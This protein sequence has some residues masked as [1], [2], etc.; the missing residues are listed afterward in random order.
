MRA[1]ISA[2]RRTDIP[3]FY[4]HWLEYHL[5]QGFVDVRNPVVKDKTY[6]VSLRPEDVHTIVLWSKNYRPFLD[7]PVSRNPAYH[8]YFNFSLV[9]CPEWER[10]VPPLE[11]RLRQARELAARWS[12]HHIN[13]RFDPILFWEGGRRNNLGAFPSLCDFMA[14]LGVFWCTFSF[15]TWYNKVKAR[16]E[17]RSLD[18][19]DPPLS[20]KV[21]ILSGLSA[22]TRPRG[23]TLESCC[24]DEL[25]A[26]EGISKG[27]CIHGPCSAAWRANAAPWHGTPANVRI[28]AARKVPTSAVTRCLAHI[29]V[30][31]ATPSRW[32]LYTAICPNLLMRV[33]QKTIGNHSD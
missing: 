4:M 30:S 11:E 27:H 2:S 15:V 8:W 6:R 13:W 24:N 14:G 5:R 25:L 33:S 3:G 16:K 26:A 28:A 7:S 17:C 23:I 1:V 21:D 31:T 22:Y 32:S 10:G 29:N 18:F 20:Q 9:D 12:P 19:Y